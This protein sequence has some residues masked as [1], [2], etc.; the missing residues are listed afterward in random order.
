MALMIVQ[1]VRHVCVV[2]IGEFHF[3]LY[4]RIFGLDVGR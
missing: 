4:Q 3:A 1:V 2:R